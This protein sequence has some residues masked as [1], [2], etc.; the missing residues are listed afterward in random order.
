MSQTAESTTSALAESRELFETVLRNLHDGIVVVNAGGMAGLRRLTWL[1]LPFLGDL[2]VLMRVN[3]IMYAG[4]TSQRRHDLVRR[5]DLR[6]RL[7]GDRH[8]RHPRHGRHIDHT[9]QRLGDAPMAA[10][11]VEASERVVPRS[12]IVTRLWVDGERDAHGGGC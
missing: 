5:R 7:H 8:R 4:T 2:R 6:R 3:D 12:S 11:S 9:R 10:W 1:P